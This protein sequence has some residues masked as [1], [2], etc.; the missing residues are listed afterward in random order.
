MKDS[1]RQSAVCTVAVLVLAAA[2]LGGEPFGLQPVPEQG[3]LLLHNGQTLSGRITRAGELYYV[4]FPNGEIR[5]KADDVEFHC[6]DIDEGYRRKRAAIQAGDVVE[7]IRMAQ[8]CLRHELFGHATMELADAMAADPTHPVIGLLQRRLQLA[9]S[10][11]PEPSCKSESV[12]AVSSLSFEQLDQMVREMPPGAVETFT[13]TIQPVLMNNC[14][15]AACHGPGTATKYRLERI[16]KGRPPSRRMTQRNLHATLQWINRRDPTDS[17]L[18]TAPTGPHGTAKAAVFSEHQVL[19]YKR[20][21]DWVCRLSGRNQPEV[22]KTV[23]PAAQPAVQAMADSAQSAVSPA[24][25][26]QP[27]ENVEVE[28][29]PVAGPSIKR[30]AELKQFVPADPFDPEIFNR[31]FFKEK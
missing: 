15:T 14:S 23:D 3:V 7:H 17:R 11:Q 4:S 24:V 31:R 2:A 18:L 8:W 1:I 28:R 16:S 13:Q 22:P 10:P 25:F 19:Q 21:V 30:G 20:M 29:P 9:I 6:R 12:S 27:V 26:E 5:V